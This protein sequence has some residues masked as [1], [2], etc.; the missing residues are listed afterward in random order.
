MKKMKLVAALALA[1]GLASI[2][3]AQ[4]VLPVANN[5]AGTEKIDKALAI[6]VPGDHQV[7]LNDKISPELKLT[8]EAGTNWVDVLSKALTKANLAAQY[9]QKDKVITVDAVK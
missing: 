7:K 5:T 3:Q 2:A 8:W 6:L 9:N 4:Q 1:I